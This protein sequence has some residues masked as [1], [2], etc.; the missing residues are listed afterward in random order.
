[1]LPHTTGSEVHA[2]VSV[3]PQRG[4]AGRLLAEA[5]NALLKAGALETTLSRLTREAALAV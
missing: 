5:T 1:L 3:R 4:L 2:R